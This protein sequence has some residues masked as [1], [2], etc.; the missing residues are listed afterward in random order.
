MFELSRRFVFA[1]LVALFTT[2]AYA[3]IVVNTEADEDINNAACSLREAITAVDIHGD[4]NGCADPATTWSKITFA[5]PGA[6]G[7]VHTI[8]LNDKLPTINNTV[9][10]DATTQGGTICTPGP[11]LRVQIINGGIVGYGLYL[12]S[13][14]TGSKIRG[15]AL[16]GF[17]GS[18]GTGIWIQS[19]ATTIGCV[20]SGMD[21]TGTTAQPN[22]YGI[23]VDAKHATIGEATASDWFPNLISA[24]SSTNISVTFGADDTLIAGNYVGVDHSGLTPLPSGYGIAVSGA[25]RTHIG[26]GFSDGPP[27]HQRNIVGVVNAPPYSANEI[28]LEGATDTVIAGNYIGVGRDGHTVLPIGIGV[29]ISINTSGNTLIG[30]NGLG[31]WDD[32]RNVIVNPSDGTFFATAIAAAN[33]STGTAIVNNFV[34]VAADGITSLAGPS[35]SA[36]D[37]VELSVNALVAR[38]MISAGDGIDIQLVSSAGFV[39]PGIAGTGGAPLNS[40]DNCFVDTAS[41]G[42]F[43]DTATLFFYNWW[44]A[45]DG[46]KP[47]GSGAYASPPVITAPFLTAPSAYCS[48]DHIFADGFGG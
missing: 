29:G 9:F 2:G 48:V 26:T 42:V 16:S 25:A 35:S 14:A 39:N 37:C 15:L 46:P 40:T 1:V 24:N 10:I 12:G 11:D 41:T 28:D 32:C 21:A 6:V 45:A 30:C 47:A 18:G 4:Y 23:Y 34:N 8:S 20:I 22:V 7:A 38:N 44:G 36:N 5:I 13:A 31:G 43:T 3:D 17:S 33:S 19:D 27:A